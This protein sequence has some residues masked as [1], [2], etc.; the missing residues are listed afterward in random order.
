MVNIELIKNSPSNSL[1][2]NFISQEIIT[3]KFAIV[4]GPKD[5]WRLV[6]RNK[7]F[8]NIYSEDNKEFVTVFAKKL[9]EKN[10]DSILISGLGLGVIPYV[11][12]GTTSII[13]IIEIDE[14]IINFIKPIGHIHPSTN[15]IHGDI[16]NFTPQRKYDVILFNHWLVYAAEDEIK[17]L[18]QKFQPYLNDNGLFYSPIKEQF[19]NYN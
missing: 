19:K 5:K 3:E 12:Q 14:E 7:S 4:K 8:G 11:C 17:I 6:N 2:Q 15:I 18:T 9:L 1:L 10:F 13:D 16:Y